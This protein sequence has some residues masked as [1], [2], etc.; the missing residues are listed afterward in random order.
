MDERL[1]LLFQGTEM[2]ERASTSIAHLKDVAKYARQFGVKSKI[3]VTPLGSVRERYYKGGVLFS[4]VHDRER[5]E[6]FAAGGRYDSLIREFKPKLTRSS[7]VCHAVGFSFGWDNLA[8]SMLSF[9][10]NSRKKKSKKPS[11]HQVVP[12]TWLGKR[13][14]LHELYLLSLML[15]DIV[16]CAGEQLR[17]SNSPLCWSRH[18][19]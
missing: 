18:A 3:Y 5:K 16:R 1:K 15:T 4:Y 14:C 10:Q 17:C 8:Q 7:E 6:V 9:Y 12:T 19:E 2:F 11:E 13:V